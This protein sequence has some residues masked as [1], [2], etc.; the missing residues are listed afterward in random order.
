M[1]PHLIEHWAEYGAYLMD[2]GLTKKWAKY[3]DVFPAHS[4]VKHLCDFYKAR[5]SVQIAAQKKNTGSRM[6]ET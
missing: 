4:F 2:E 6:M 1:I 3:P 5:D